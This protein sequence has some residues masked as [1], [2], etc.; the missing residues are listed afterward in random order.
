MEK[1]IFS[2]RVLY[3][4]PTCA[5]EV[6]RFPLGSIIENDTLS[7]IGFV[8]RH[9]RLHSSVSH[10][11]GMGIF[12]FVRL[13]NGRTWKIQLFCAWHDILFLQGVYISLPYVHAIN[14]LLIVCVV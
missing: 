9:T 11:K 2:S 7:P 5:I 4:N 12:D 14:L 13:R 10:D 6:R 8:A 3:I 1:D